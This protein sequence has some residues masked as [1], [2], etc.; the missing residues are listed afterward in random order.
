MDAE[1]HY[2]QNLI[3]QIH[4]TEPETQISQA[5]PKTM[6]HTKPVQN[7]RILDSNH[8]L[9]LNCQHYLTLLFSYE[10]IMGEQK[11]A[12]FTITIEHST[13]MRPN[14]RSQDR[15]MRM[16]THSLTSIRYPL[17]IHENLVYEINSSNLT[18]LEN[19][20]LGAYRGESSG[21]RR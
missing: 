9:C 5:P 14:I 7:P 16:I 20:T 8:S 10:T 11:L 19:R 13:L 12:N 4:Y 15:K 3:H 1:I 6:P 21:T 18:S 17:C 2:L